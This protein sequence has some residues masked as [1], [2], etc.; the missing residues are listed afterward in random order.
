MTDKERVAESFLIPVVVID[1]ANKAV[2]AA[3][4]LLAGGI[5]VMEITLRTEAGLKAIENVQRSCPDLLVGAGTVL[6]LDKCKE[7]VSKGAGFIVSPGFDREIVEYCVK[8]NVTIFPGCVTPTEISAAFKHGINVVK[9]FPA[10]IYGG[11]AAIKALSAP[12]PGVKFIPTGGIDN[13]NLSQFIIPEVFGIGG[14]WLCD[15]KQIDSG[16]FKGITAKCEAA[17]KIV[18]QTRAMK[19]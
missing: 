12:F 5:R 15:R 8:N 14:G 13:E 2:D 17:L 6:S 1:D 10:Q 4:A 19:K 11:I 9:F 3:K 18:N 16:D 7:A